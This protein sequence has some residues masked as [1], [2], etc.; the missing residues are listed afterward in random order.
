MEKL[1]N[2]R[3]LGIYSDRD[4]YFRAEYQVGQRLIW[5]RCQHRLDCLECVRR[6]DELMPDVWAAM[7]SAIALAEDYSR[8]QIPKFWSR[9]DMS[10]REGNR[11]DV[12]GI[13]ITTDLEV[14]RFYLSENHD[15]DYS[16]PTYSK[17]DYWD[18]E[19]FLLPTLPDRH[20]VY[21][22]READGRLH[23]ESAGA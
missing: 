10:R 17:D 4:G 23:V 9:H 19:P 13:T 5:V 16:S 18:N 7:S 20:H 11:L 14:A 1:M 8:T 15:F 3:P 2:G 21:V 22:I 6:V 12:W